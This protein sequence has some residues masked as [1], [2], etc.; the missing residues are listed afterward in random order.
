MVKDIQKASLT[1][2]GESHQGPRIV[3][4]FES[5][6]LKRGAIS[7]T[8]TVRGLDTA[9]NIAEFVSCWFLKKKRFEI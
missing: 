2:L 4:A 8:F 3:T 1:K 9:I 6:N 7:E 5:L